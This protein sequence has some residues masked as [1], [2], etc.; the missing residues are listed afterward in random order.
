[1]RLSFCSDTHTMHGQL[2]QQV[3]A[4]RP[5]VLVHCGDFS[6]HGTPED[7]SKFAEWCGM[8]IRKQYARH[9]VVI[10]GNHDLCL[11]EAHPATRERWP[12]GNATGRALFEDAGATYL[13]DSG[14]EVCGLRFY[15]TPY[16]PRFF[17]W[18]F[19]I[20][21]EEQDRAIFE[22][23]R[24]AT[25]DVLVAHGPPHGIRDL[26]PGNH[27]V[28]SK[29]LRELGRGRII[30]FGHIH[31]GYGLSLVGGT[32][33]VNASTCTGDYEPTNPLITIDVEPR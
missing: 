18:A 9:V 3:I 23:A 26:A 14:A 19:Q 22:A 27:H 6:G 13:Q 30:A 33:Y 4:A 25:P 16:S 28:G 8:L 21:S 24:L 17:D 12:S 29:A 2:T 11:D 5:D 1:M 20:D 15:G 32:T 10:A 7:V 31:E